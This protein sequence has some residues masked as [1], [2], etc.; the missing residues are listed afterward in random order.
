MGKKAYKG[1]GLTEVE[2]VEMQTWLFSMVN[3]TKSISE[4][5]SKTA[6]HFEG[7]TLHYALYVLGNNMG[8]A[9]VKD[10]IGVA[11]VLNPEEL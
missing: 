4:M 10:M 5:I 7:T 9:Q 8:A 3:E 2:V 6:A 11:H 1:L